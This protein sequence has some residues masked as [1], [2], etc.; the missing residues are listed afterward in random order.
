MHVDAVRHQT[1]SRARLAG[2]RQ[3]AGVA[4]VRQQPRGGLRVLAGDAAAPVRTVH[5][6]D[7]RRVQPAV[8]QGRAGIQQQTALLSRIAGTRTDVR[9]E[10]GDT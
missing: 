9:C 4:R 6:R 1:V 8:G 2:G 5:Q 3:R 7:E 10:Q